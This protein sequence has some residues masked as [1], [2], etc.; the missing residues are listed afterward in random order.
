MYGPETL[1][2]FSLYC[3]KYNVERANMIEKLGNCNVFGLSLKICG[4]AE[5]YNRRR[6]IYQGTVNLL[7]GKWK[8]R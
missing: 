8:I 2:H 4:S 3:K 5:Y 6:V 7:V 1:K